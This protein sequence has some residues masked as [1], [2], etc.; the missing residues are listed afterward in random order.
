VK[1]HELYT[2]AD[3]A[4]IT[5]M[6]D[7]FRDNDRNVYKSAVSTLA[8]TKKLR[9]VFIQKKPLPEQYAW[10]LKT[11]RGKPADTIGEHLLQAWFMAGNQPMLAAFCDAM[12]IEH[13]G[14]GS[15]TGDLPEAMD[16]AQLD[17]AVDQ[18]VAAYDPKR[19][20]LYLRVFNL[21]KPGGWDSLSAKLAG[22][23]RLVLA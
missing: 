21:Q 2:A 7:W 15:V 6:L 3:P 9:L 4:L 14:K 13:D 1:A 16:A 8:Q 5:Q 12:G 23:P 10:I 11:L 18:L 19:V 22:D 17:A 20:T